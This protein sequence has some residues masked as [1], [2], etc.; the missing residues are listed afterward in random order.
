MAIY[1]TVQMAFWT[2]AKIADTYSVE[3]KF[4]YLY[5]LTN[6]HTNLC[7]CY[8]ISYR[9]IAFETGLTPQNVVKLIDGLQDKGV[10]G[11]STDTSELL[12][13]NWHRYNW[14]TSEKFRKPL[15]AEIQGIKDSHFKEYL[16]N[17]YEFGDAE[18][19]IDTVSKKQDTVSEVKDKPVKPV[20]TKR[21]YGEN[22]KVKL[23]DEEYQKLCEEY[24][25]ITANEAINY[26]DSYKI[27]KGYTTKSDYMTI[28]RWVVEAVNRNSKPKNR[29]FARE[30]NVNDFL[31]Q[32][33]TG[34]M[35]EQTGSI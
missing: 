19:R 17:L 33:A 29:N 21:V 13:V 14:T 6:P 15:G 5:C 9:Q 12:V 26:L 11:Y 7:G 2:D 18:Y 10:V 4:L 28:R 16:S 8:E 23:T 32:Q 34:G 24:G 20:K 31:M 25:D 30:N 27:E 22:G 1:R 3:E 35:Y